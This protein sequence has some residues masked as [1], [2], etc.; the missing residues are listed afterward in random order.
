VTFEEAVD[1]LFM[2]HRVGLALWRGTGG[3]GRWWGEVGV[4]SRREACGRRDEGSPTKCRY[5]YCES[6]S[7]SEWVDCSVRVG[8]LRRVNSVCTSS[9]RVIHRRVLS[10]GSPSGFRVS[11]VAIMSQLLV[12]RDSAKSKTLTSEQLEDLHAA[13]NSVSVITSR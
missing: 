9:C 5:W 8:R 6:V 1:S 13:F 3:V 12:R 7:R 11:V 4:T 10:T 2:C